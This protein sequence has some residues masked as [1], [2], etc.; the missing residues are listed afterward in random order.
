MLGVRPALAA[1]EHLHGLLDG[2][3]IV[4]GERARVRAR[5]RERLVALVQ[6]LGERERRARREAEA[7]VRLALQAGEVVQE[8]RELCRGLRLFGDDAGPALAFRAYRLRPR[9]VPEALRASLG[10]LVLVLLE[11][12]VEP[13]AGVFAGGRGE[14]RVHLPV[15]AR[16]EL[17]D[18]LLAVHEDRERRRLHAAD[19]GLV[20]AA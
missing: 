9:L 17:A 8:R 3:D 6:R 11:R 19:C 2:S 12:L 15:V 13:A 18:F 1:G 14:G 7:A 4:F 10:V 16:H 20:E 5:I